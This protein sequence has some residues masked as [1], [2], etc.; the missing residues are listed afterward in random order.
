MDHKAVRTLLAALLLMAP[1]TPALASDR[2]VDPEAPVTSVRPVE[3]VV[4]GTVTYQDLEG[5]FY[6]VDGWMLVGDQ[7]E[8]A[9]YLGQTVVVT[10][11][12]YKGPS[13]Y[14]VRALQVKSIRVLGPEVS[15]PKE[16]RVDGKPV[17]FDQGPEVIDGVLMIP[18]RAVVEAAGGEIEWLG[19]TRQVRVR[20]LGLTV[21]FTIG[22]DKADLNEDG[23]S[24]FARNL[25]PIAKAPVIMGNRT[26]VSVDALALMGL[27]VR[28]TTDGVLEIWTKPDA[29]F[30]EKGTIAEISDGETF[31]FLLKG[32]P[33]A[34]GEPMLMWV[35]VPEDAVIIVGEKTGTTD[36]LKVGQTVEVTLAGPILESYPALGY[37]S[38]VR[39]VM[40][41]PQPPEVFTERGT[42]TEIDAGESFRFLLK[43]GP[44]SSGEPTLIWV[45]VPED[46]VITVGDQ[47]GTIADLKVGQTV[48]VT[49]AGPLLLSYPAQGGAAAVRVLLDVK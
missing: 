16:I 21:I 44:M 32:E 2:P 46:A 41:E 47:A 30:M 43:G 31:R 22:E 7:E 18:L 3:R 35:T 33:M 38:A 6:A 17:S 15:V 29:A 36:D 1:A 25:V 34:N 4:T 8:F 48:E 45:T 9:R 19:E 10:G 23:V 5:G 39:V 27:Y 14:M 42:I 20:M 26:L 28:W 11:T 37:A 40:D 24:Y 12:P 13:I 49:F